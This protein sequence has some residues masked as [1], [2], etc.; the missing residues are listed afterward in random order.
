M[1]RDFIFVTLFLCALLLS[2]C[3]W[4][5]EESSRYTMTTTAQGDVY[6]LDNQTGEVHHVSPE[7][8]FLLHDNTPVLKVGAY[9]EMEDVSAKG[10]PKFLEYL[11]RGQFEKSQFA[12]V[13]S[14]KDRRKDTP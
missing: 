10:E 7:G 6:R 3:K 9:Y 13:N 14:D 5:L 12:I 11:G 1:K 8:M 2:G 4:P